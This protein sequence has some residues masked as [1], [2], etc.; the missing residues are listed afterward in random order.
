MADQEREDRIR[1][2]KAHNWLNNSLTKEFYQ[3]SYERL[4]LQW[5]EST[6]VEAREKIHA[7]FWGLKQVES[8]MKAFV[9]KHKPKQQL[10]ERVTDKWKQTRESR[11][12]QL[13]NE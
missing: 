8:A 2:E 7:Q 4:F 9:E 12:R 11:R 13:K 6:S 3:M 5:G 1:A 10:Q